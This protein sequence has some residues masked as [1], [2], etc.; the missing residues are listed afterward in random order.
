MSRDDLAETLMSDGGDDDDSDGD[1]DLD[2]S[3]IPTEQW[4]TLAR[5]VQILLKLGGLNRK[6]KRQDEKMAEI[7]KRLNHHRD[8]LEPEALDQVGMK[9]LIKDLKDRRRL[10]WLLVSGLITSWLAAMAALVV[11]LIKLGGG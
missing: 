7:E 11:A 9:E 4:N 1:H 6:N 3:K 2:I 5:S 8:L 10:R